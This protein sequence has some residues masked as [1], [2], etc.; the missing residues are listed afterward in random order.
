M[1]ATPAEQ[2]C[3][4]HIAT[5]LKSL[6]IQHGDVLLVHSSFKTLGPVPGGIETVIRALEQSIGPTGTLLFPALSYMQQPHHIHDTRHTP[7][8]VGA[9]PEYFRQ[10]KGTQRSLH[11]THSLCGMGHHIDVLFAD[12]PLDDTPCG[13]HSPFRNMIDLGAKIAMLGCGLRPNTTMHAIEEFV[14]PPYLFDGH[15][16]YH[17][18][19][20][21]G[22]VIQK[23]YRTHSFDGWAQRYER[24]A[25]L[26]DTHFLR[27]GHVLQAETFILNTPALKEAVIDQ[28]NKDPLFFVEAV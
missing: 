8:C 11:P 15:C 13:P 28:L 7:C 12:H 18:T 9:M 1:T 10:R 22:Q 19:D 17:I 2:T 4:Q 14:E 26:P 5:A 25:N 27:R 21:A 23:T 3:Q 16:L 6:G 20:S 24:V